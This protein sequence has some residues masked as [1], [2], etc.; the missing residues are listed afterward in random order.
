[1][2]GSLGFPE[3][4]TPGIKAGVADPPGM[5]IVPAVMH[6]RINLLDRNA[7]GWSGYVEG[8]TDPDLRPLK[9]EDPVS[10]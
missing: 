10:P 4:R 7:P 9:G 8:F 2:I 3:R 5:A 1:M 6:A